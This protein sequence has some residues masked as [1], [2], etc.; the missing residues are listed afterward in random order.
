MKM[1]AHRLLIALLA[2]AIAATA[3]VQTHTL[4]PVAVPKEIYRADVNAGKEIKEAL[5]RAK[6]KDKR[7]M[8]VFGGNWCY[9]CH[10]LDAALHDPAIAPTFT[11]YYELVHVDIGQGERNGDLVRKYKINLEKGVPAVSL[12]DSTGKLIFND[13]GGEFEAARRMT[14]EDLL[15]FLDNWKAK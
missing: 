2:L 6:A 14:E 10:V 8:L 12:L 4:K 15:A 7:V 1:Y 3:Q 13:K 9:D 5:S 11:K